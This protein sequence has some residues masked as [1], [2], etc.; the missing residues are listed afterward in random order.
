ML[1]GGKTG[2]KD[3][4]GERL[5]S[6]YISRFKTDYQP[7]LKN[8]VVSG[9]L[10]K[11]TLFFKT[12][13]QDKDGYGDLAEVLFKL[14]TGSPTDESLAAVRYDACCNLLQIRTFDGMSWGWSPGHAPGSANVLENDWIK[15]DCAATSVIPSGNNLKVNWKIIPKAGMPFGTY[16]LFMGCSD[17]EGQTAPWTQEGTTFTIS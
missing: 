5:P 1:K 10:A 17:N 14:G 3:A 16:N 9:K 4:Y 11:G 8:V 7:T 15:L 13:Y 12:K 2:I 6:T